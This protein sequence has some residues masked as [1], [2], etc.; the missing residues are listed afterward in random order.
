[1]RHLRTPITLVSVSALLLGASLWL[2][3]SGHESRV[4]SI[5]AGT[6]IDGRGGFRR[7]VVITI[8]GSRITTIED[9]SER[10][11]TYDLA[12]LTVLPGLI[13]THVHLASHFGKDGRASCDGETPEEHFSYMSDNARLTLLGGFTTVQSLGS[14]E[15][16]QL[17][18][19][20]AAGK[21]VGPR[22]LTSGSQLANTT[23]TDKQI[24]RYVRQVRASG[25]DVVKI[26]ASRSIRDGGDQTFADDQIRVACE[27]ARLAGI[28]TWVHAHSASAVRAATVAGCDAVAHGSQSTDAEF[29]LMSQHRTFFEPNIGLVSQNYVENKDRYLG[30]GNFGEEAINWYVSEG[31]PAKTAMFRRALRHKRLKLIMGTDAAAGAHGQNAREIIY[32][33]QVGG[34]APMD[35]LL[36]ST[37]HAA[38]ALGLGDRIGSI[39]PGMHADIIAVDGDPL[40]DIDALNRVVFV[41][42][43]GRVYKNVVPTSRDY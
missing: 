28:R 5:R 41:M 25:A 38:E 35:A 17:R 33:V 3:A 34:Q 15:D 31:I 29:D 9:E 27:E 16:L 8:R 42:K 26:F 20:I 4:F 7:N 23:F 24:R 22:V 13:D 12:G 1:V 30:I 32:R 19:A 21:A 39:A 43:N 10:Q 2:R 6:L 11:S 40:R 14:S 37:S 36:A 18:E